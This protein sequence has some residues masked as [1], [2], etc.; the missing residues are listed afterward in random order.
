MALVTAAV[1]D[2]T[3]TLAN[4][5]LEAGTAG[6]TAPD[7]TAVPASTCTARLLVAPPTT[8]ASVI[9]AWIRSTRVRPAPGA[10]PTATFTVCRTL[11][12]YLPCPA[13]SPPTTTTRP[14]ATSTLMLAPAACWETARS[15]AETTPPVG[16]TASSRSRSTPAG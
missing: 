2:A 5:S 11:P 10:A 9:C 4:A 14:T 6:G 16:N 7:D 1:P 3:V 13:T 12:K 15:P 8:V